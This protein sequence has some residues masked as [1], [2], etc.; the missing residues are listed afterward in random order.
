MPPAT[1]TAQGYAVSNRNSGT[2]TGKA[3][4]ESAAGKVT[5]IAS[6]PH[7]DWFAGVLDPDGQSTVN[8]KATATWGWPTGGATLPLT[9]SK[10][11]FSQQVSLDSTQE[12]TILFSK[13]ADSTG[14]GKGPSGNFLPGGFA[15]V[16]TTGSCTQNSG[17]LGSGTWLN[18]DTGN[19]PSAGC[20]TADFAKMLNK[21][22]LIPLFDDATGNGS[23]GKYH[24]VGYAAF[25]MTGYNFGGSFKTSPAP[26]NGNDRCVKGY[27]TRYADLNEALEFGPTGGQFGAAI[28]TLTD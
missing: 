6:D 8:A 7:E 13:T 24:V 19:T 27:F 5:V 18:S 1:A 3:E 23:Q 17:I 2:A 20:G 4:V 25:K 16:D 9:F 22:I 26:C 11:E 14:C 10:C 28:V 21:V 15:W 12:D